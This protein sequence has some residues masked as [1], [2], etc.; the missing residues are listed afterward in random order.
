MVRAPASRNLFPFELSLLRKFI[1]G[2]FSLE[3][4]LLKKPVR[5]IPRESRIPLQARAQHFAVDLNDFPHRVDAALTCDSQSFKIVEKRRRG[6]FRKKAIHDVYLHS[7]IVVDLDPFSK[8]I[9]LS[10]QSSTSFE[11][12]FTGENVVLLHAALNGILEQFRFVEKY[13]NLVGAVSSRATEGTSVLHRLED[14]VYAEAETGEAVTYPANSALA[15][16]SFFNTDA[17]ASN[18]HASA[19]AEPD[20]QEPLPQ[21]QQSDIILHSSHSQEE[22][23]PPG[24]VYEDPVRADVL[25]PL[26]LS[27]LQFQAPAALPTPDPSQYSLDEAIARAKAAASEVSRDNFL[28]SSTR[29]HTAPMQPP[30]TPA[31]STPISIQV[32][33]KAVAFDEPPDVMVLSPPVASSL[34]VVEVPLAAQSNIY[35]PSRYDDR[36]SSPEQYPRSSTHM[37]GSPP[38][39]RQ[40]ITGLLYQPDAPSSATAGDEASVGRSSLGDSM[41]DDIVKLRSRISAVRRL[42]DTDAELGRVENP[43]ELQFQVHQA[44]HSDLPALQSQV[45]TDD[46]CMPQAVETRNSD[47]AFLRRPESSFASRSHVDSRGATSSTPNAVTATPPL[48][49]RPQRPASGLGLRRFPSFTPTSDAG[50]TTPSAEARLHHTPT[51]PRGPRPPTRTSESRLRVSFSDVNA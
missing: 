47:L 50:S 1:L 3:I 6:V 34:R 9:R 24:L 8:V 2:G 33:R 32:H 39:S 16:N 27:T 30:A 25:P 11:L 46:Y 51:A 18:G 19:A 49:E 17:L 37:H 48:G 36:S 15:P 44:Y 10:D 5:S 45:N 14:E 28:L 20:V 42:L 23:L 4:T 21:Q 40:N 13:V 12:F 41:G 35:L 22:A 7:F 31:P 38:S 26:N 43:E 29:L